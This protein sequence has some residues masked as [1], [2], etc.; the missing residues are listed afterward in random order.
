MKLLNC[1]FVSKEAQRF[2]ARSQPRRI[3][4]FPYLADFEKCFPGKLSPA[5]NH[6]WKIQWKELVK[7]MLQWPLLAYQEMGQ[8]CIIRF[9][10]WDIHFQKL[11]SEKLLIDFVKMLILKSVWH[12]ISAKRAFPDSSFSPNFPFLPGFSCWCNQGSWGGTGRE[13]CLHRPNISWLIM[14]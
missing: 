7:E 11:S 4:C 8:L 12:L 1:C 2:P 10:P 13:R 3:S 9:K 6:F 5:M 14:N